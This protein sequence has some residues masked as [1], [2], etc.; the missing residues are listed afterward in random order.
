MATISDE[1]VGVVFD[2]GGGTVAAKLGSAEIDMANSV[3]NVVAELDVV[4]IAA[5]VCVAIGEVGIGEIGEIVGGLVGQDWGASEGRCR[6]G[7][8]YVSGE[9]RRSVGISVPVEK[10]N[11]A[12]EISAD[13]AA[14][15]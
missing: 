11:D 7:F 8:E 13:V 6:N 9:L 5:G 3:A 10:S 1:S 12:P 2:G 15:C 4:V 14:T